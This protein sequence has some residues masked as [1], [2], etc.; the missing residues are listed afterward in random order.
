MKIEPFE[1]IKT[2]LNNFSRFYYYTESDKW[3]NFSLGKT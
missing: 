3:R 2:G 1:R